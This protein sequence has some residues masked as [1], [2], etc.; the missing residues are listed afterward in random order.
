MVKR[1]SFTPTQRAR[2]FLDADGICHICGRKITEGAESWH[3]E[4]VKALGLS[5][6]DDPSNWR[7][8]HI[9]CHATKTRKDVAIM[10]K[11]D[12]QMKAHQGIKMPR[13]KIASRPFPKSNRKR[14]LWLRSMEE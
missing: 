8:A 9:D 12:R 3:V 4:H 11:A 5:G 10:R 2:I 14:A 6:A 1:K 7:P 13:K